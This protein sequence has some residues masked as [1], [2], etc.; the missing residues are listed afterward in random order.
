MKEIIENLGITYNDVCLMQLFGAIFYFPALVYLGRAEKPRHQKKML[1]T[2]IILV[3]MV[4]V[5]NHFALEWELEKNFLFSAT[6]MLLPL[7]IFACRSRQREIY[8][9]AERFSKKIHLER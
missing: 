8:E 5:V 2:I 6:C 4:V 3:L 1:A 9:E 7:L